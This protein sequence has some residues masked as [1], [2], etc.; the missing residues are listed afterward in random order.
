MVCKMGVVKIAGKKEKSK[1]QRPKIGIAFGGGGIRGAAH[2]GVLQVL[3]EYNI[4]VDMVC[5]TSF[6]AFIA[7]LV[8]SGFDWRKID[9]LFKEI[10]IDNVLK[11]RPRRLGLIPADQYKEIVSICTHEGKIEDTKIPLK[12]IAVDLVSRQK[13]VLDHG[14]IASAVRA[15]SAV[16]GVFTP[17]IIGDMMLVDGYLLDNVPTDEVRRMGADIVIG[18]S[19]KC[20]DTSSLPKTMVDVIMR[21]MDIMADNKQ[22]VEA[23][24]IL[25]PINKP[26][27]FLD[28]KSVNDCREMGVM[29]ARE[30]IGSLLSLIEAKC[31]N[32]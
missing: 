27:S 13:V 9:L 32:K 12:I 4:P 5:G 30:N 28:K 6:G 15:S 29:T 11:V 16:P 19:L 1:K 10:D 31:A 21:S 3:E 17:E 24:W 18:I 25:E 23:D 7:A 26:V 22:T 20:P 2:I 8:A 14:D